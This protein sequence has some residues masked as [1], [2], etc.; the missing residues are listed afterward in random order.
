VRDPLFRNI[1]A[2]YGISRDGETAFIEMATASGLMLLSREERNPLKTSSVGTGDLMR[3]ALD[4]AVKHIVLGIGGSATN[5]GGMGVAEALGVKFFDAAGVGLQPVGENLSRVHKVDISQLH[6]RLGATRITILCDVDNP[7]YGPHGAAFVFAPQKGA[8]EAMVRQLDEGL[9]HYGQLLEHQ[10][11]KSMDFAGGGAAGGLAVSLAAIV[12][13]QIRRGAEFIMDFVGLEDHIRS[14]GLVITGEGKVDSQTLS[15]KVVKGVT[16]LAQKWRKQVWVV[17]GKSDLTDQELKSIGV[18]QLVVLA[19]G[20]TPEPEAM[21]R[22]FDLLKD[23]VS[24]A[25][26]A[27]KPD[28]KS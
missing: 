4:R 2:T 9:K 10:F 28:K 1:Q 20:K 6:S 25:W 16:D 11:H 7:L 21:S 24:K 17:A 15:G 23:R 3:D 14:A 5:D 26:L 8:S 19:D 22:A 18:Q 13:V 27:M 12:P